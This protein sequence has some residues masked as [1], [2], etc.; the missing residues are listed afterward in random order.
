M[1]G[2][3]ARDRISLAEGNLA[4]AATLLSQ[5]GPGVRECSAILGQTADC[6]RSIQN[7]CLPAG[8]GR[9]ELSPLIRRVQQKALLV[10]QLLNSAV[11]YYCGWLS[12][13]PATVT[14]Y[15]PG[16]EINRGVGSGALNIEA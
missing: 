9:V 10:Q 11:T 8:S 6:L 2:P 15:L 3:S 14:E 16:A 4:R 5:M 7:E 12:A 13:G 1:T